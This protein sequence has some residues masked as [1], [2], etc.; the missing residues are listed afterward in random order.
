MNKVVT[1]SKSGS[2]SRTPKISLPITWLRDMGI[3][4]ENRE[5]KIEYNELSKEIII[6][7]AK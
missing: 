3:N 7:S 4:P 2:G 6:K 5:I 1:F